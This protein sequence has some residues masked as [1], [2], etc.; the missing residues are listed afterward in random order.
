MH[1]SSR[2]ARHALRTLV[3]PRQLP[4]RLFCSVSAS[5]P[6]SD[7]VADGGG[8]AGQAELLRRFTPR[9]FNPRFAYTSRPFFPICAKNMRNGHGRQV[10]KKKKKRVRGRG[11]S[12]RGIKLQH[13]RGM[14]VDPETWDGGNRAYYTKFPKWPGAKR[15]MS[16]KYQQLETLS[17]ARLRKFIEHGRLDTRYPITQRHLFESR[18]VKR[19]RNGVRLF[20][21][22]DYPFPYKVDIE[23]ASV[24]QSSIDMIKRVGGSVTV[25]YMERVALRAHIKPWKFEVLPKTA[26]PNLAM[27]HYMEKMRARGA[28]VR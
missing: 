18:C 3:R 12:Q 25:V 14:D 7:K 5:T 22:N 1:A 8:G 27:V 21:Y 2:L 11:K 28:K 17:L 15:E 24:D 4:C 19:V 13:D 10:Q 20:N 9:P 6:D 16:S 26:R 23:V